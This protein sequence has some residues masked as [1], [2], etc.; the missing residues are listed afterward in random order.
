MEMTYQGIIFDFNGVLLWDSHLQE[1]AWREFAAAQFGI[2]L[3]DEVMA[4]E[5]HGRNNQHTLEFLAGTPL[6]AQRAEHLSSQKEA[7]YRSLCL[8][9]GN[10]FKLSPGAVSLLDALSADGIPRTIATASGHENLLFFIE[11]LDLARW[12]DPERIIFDDG[13]RPGKP[14]GES[15]LQAAQMIGLQPGSCVVVE[16]SA[17]GIQAAQAAGIGYITA[18]I[19][20]G[21]NLSGST[22]DGID[23]SIENLTQLPREDLFNTPD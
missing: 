17:A 12:F 19:H 16:D 4:N 22:M 3:T 14:A 2:A 20:N 5:I 21:R 6:N 7:L 8:A 11:H 23:L 9:Q 15:Y 10:D 1:Q 13:A 18:L